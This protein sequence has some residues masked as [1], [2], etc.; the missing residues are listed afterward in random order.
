MTYHAYHVVYLQQASRDWN[1]FS[2][3]HVE[4]LSPI[5]KSVVVFED[6]VFKVLTWDH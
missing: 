4:V 1:S 3:S 2:Q 5:Y 6:E